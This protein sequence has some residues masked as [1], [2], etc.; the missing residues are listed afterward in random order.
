[1]SD[2][3]IIRFAGHE[4]TAREIIYKNHIMPERQ[5]ALMSRPEIEECINE[6]YKCFYIGED[7][8]LV[9]NEK[10]EEFCKLTTWIER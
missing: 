5:L 9:P 2:D 7:W 3:F 1:M 8:M 6:N 4:K 10:Y